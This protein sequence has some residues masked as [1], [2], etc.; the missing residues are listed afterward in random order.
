MKFTYTIIKTAKLQ[1]LRREL[2]KMTEASERL[3][4]TNIELAEDLIKL[5]KEKE[6]E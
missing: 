4:K 5:Q 3:L 6:G 1:S 2:E